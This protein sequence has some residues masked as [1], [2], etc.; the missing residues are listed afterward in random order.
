MVYSVWS[1]SVGLEV[2]MPRLDIYIAEHCFGCDE[3][4]RLAGAVVSRFMGLS[5]RV[6]DLVR[7]PDERPDSLVAVPSYVL[8][9]RV[10]SLGNP[11]QEDL[12]C[13]LE[14]LL[15]R[16]PSAGGRHGAS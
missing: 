13:D 12:F 10:I 2:D 4:R 6:V 8:D 14:R 16:S 15:D 1:R 7:E 5:V 9:G 11:R 3:A